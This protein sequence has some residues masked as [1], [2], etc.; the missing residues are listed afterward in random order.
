M[1]IKDVQKL[2]YEGKKTLAEEQ[3]RILLNLEKRQGP[4]Y[5]QSYVMKTASGEEALMIRYL[6]LINGRISLIIYPDTLQIENRNI[7]PA[8][9]TF[10]DVVPIGEEAFTNVIDEFVAELESAKSCGEK[11]ED[12]QK[13]PSNDYIQ[14]IYDYIRNRQELKKLYNELTFG[15]V[16]FEKPVVEE[17]EEEFSEDDDEDDKPNNDSGDYFT[18]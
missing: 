3:R 18:F 14:N 7:T 16:N 4:F 10:G 5:K 1:K 17:T 13:V 9:F 11:F 6:L 15:H 12:P 2:L 8:A